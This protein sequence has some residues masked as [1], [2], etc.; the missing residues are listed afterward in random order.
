[1]DEDLIGIVTYIDHEEH[2]SVDCQFVIAATEVCDT[3]DE[4]LEQA[5]DQALEYLTHHYG[6]SWALALEDSL[7]T[8]KVDIMT[9]GAVKEASF[10]SWKYA[11]V[12][13]NTII[14]ESNGM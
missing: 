6:E 12:D 3:E 1:M 13:G 8:V 7:I 2:D 10:L 4:V 5:S 9:P 14:F 11:S